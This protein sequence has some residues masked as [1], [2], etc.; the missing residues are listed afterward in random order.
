MKVSRFS[1]CGS[2]HKNYFHSDRAKICAHYCCRENSFSCVSPFLFSYQN[3][4]TYL[5]TELY[6]NT[7]V[8]PSVAY[9]SLSAQCS[10]VGE[11]FTSDS[12]ISE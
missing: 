4:S 10:L 12:L 7:L 9:R 5:K 6:R 1:K 11:H 3:L 8:R 2:T